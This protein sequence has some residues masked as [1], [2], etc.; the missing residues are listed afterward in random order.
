[1]GPLHARA[2]P[3]FRAISGPLTKVNRGQSRVPADS[4]T[5]SSAAMTAVIRQIPKLIVGFDSLTRST[6]K[7]QV[8][9]DLRTLVTLSLVPS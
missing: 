2:Q 5:A 4:R 3:R 9:G 7:A 8:S 1:M 6:L